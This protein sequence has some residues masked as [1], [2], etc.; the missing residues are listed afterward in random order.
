VTFLQAGAP[1]FWLAVLCTGIGAGVGAIVLTR[2][3][4]IIQHVVWAGSGTHIL[5]VAS[6][7]GAWRH[8]LVLLGAGA[9]VGIGQLAWC[10]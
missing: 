7:A 5:D 6:R 8:I 10:G 3:L 4:Q 2:L 1:R 9:V